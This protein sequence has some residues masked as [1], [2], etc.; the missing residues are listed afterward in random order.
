MFVPGSPH[1]LIT[2]TLQSHQ[3]SFIQEPCQPI[4]ANDLFCTESVNV[5][6]ELYVNYTTDFVYYSGK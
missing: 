3:Q 1:G 5:R 2:K 4:L 6:K